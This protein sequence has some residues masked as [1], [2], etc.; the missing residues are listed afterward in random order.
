MIG[1]HGLMTTYGRFPVCIQRANPAHS[2]FLVSFFSSISS[3][4]FQISD[5]KMLPLCL[6]MLP[7]EITLSES[8]FSISSKL[9]DKFEGMLC[10]A[11]LC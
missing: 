4:Q 10:V 7:L 9:K 11:F 2:I 8:H 3:G 6:K 1:Y 5:Q